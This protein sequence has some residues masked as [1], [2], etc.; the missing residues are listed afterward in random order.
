M[1]GEKT[2]EAIKKMGDVL[3]EMK[4][5][6]TETI[7]ALTLLLGS[8]MKSWKKKNPNDKNIRK[9]VSHI[10]TFLLKQIGEENKNNSSN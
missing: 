4:I 7:D 9:H 1:K 2:L 8:C 6:M 10:G 3:E 5:P